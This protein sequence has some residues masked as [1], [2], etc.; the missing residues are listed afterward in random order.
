MRDLFIFIFS[1][2][3]IV[4]GIVLMLVLDCGSIWPI[5]SE[6]AGLLGLTYLGCQVDGCDESIC[7][8]EYDY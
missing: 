4:G 6:V 3:C 7:D 5:L 2:L 8:D 1:M